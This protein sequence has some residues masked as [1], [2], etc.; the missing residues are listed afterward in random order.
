MS[1]DHEYGYKRL[2]TYKGPEVEI[3]KVCP[4]CGEKVEVVMAELNKGSNTTGIVPEDAEVYATMPTTR[5][6]YR[7]GYKKN[8]TRYYWIKKGYKIR[9]T[10][11]N[12]IL[13]NT[14]KG[15]KNIEDLVDFWNNRK[16]E[17]LD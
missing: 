3:L 16:G 8:L 12:C 11:K 1:K 4:F 13:R 6:N 9:C 2:E 15:W 5:T 10:T 14:T 17:Y 7:S